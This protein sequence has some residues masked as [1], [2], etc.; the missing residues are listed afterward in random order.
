MTG[1]QSFDDHHQALHSQNQS[2]SGQNAPGWDQTGPAQPRPEQQSFAQQQPGQQLPGQQQ[3][4]QQAATPPAYGQSGYPAPVPV[5]VR[6]KSQMGARLAA[7][8]TRDITAL[9]AAGITVVMGILLLV[10]PSLT[11]LKDNT[12]D[13]VEGTMTFSARGSIGL[14]STAQRSL[15]PGDALEVG[16]LEVM[17]QSLAQPLAGMLT[18]S[19]LLVLLGGMLMLTTARQLGAIVAIMGVVPQVIIS[20]VTALGVLITT[21]SPSPSEPSD[22]NAS[23]G[24]IA[25][26]ISTGAGVYLTIG[27]YVIIIV[28]AAVVALRH[29]SSRKLAALPNAIANPAAGPATGPHMQHHGTQPYPQQSGPEDSRP[30]GN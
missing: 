22:F 6:Q 20:A 25:S 24:P 7:F 9:V 18:L 26:G 14:S 15:S 27:A 16:F 2:P 23:S 11:W 30:A 8:I 12:F 1:P 5:A 17:L 4:G 10:T 19:A 3:P 29:E 21:D 13:M 28:C